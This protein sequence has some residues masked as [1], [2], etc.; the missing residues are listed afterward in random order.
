MA[1]L[2]GLKYLNDTY[3]H[4]AG[5]EAIAAVSGELRKASPQGACI[6]R[7]GGDEFLIM[8]ALDKDSTEPQLIAGK[9]DE[10]LRL[11]NEK[12]AR[13]FTIGASLGWVFAPLTEGSKEFDQL[14][15]EADARMYEHRK[16][17]DLHRRG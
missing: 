15:E 9:V 12:N 1:D 5:D 6:V 2:N 14:I 10:G 3:G 16:K 8:A 17:R 11:Y 7:T 13:P 4:T